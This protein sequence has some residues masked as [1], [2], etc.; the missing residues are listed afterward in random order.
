MPNGTPSNNSPPDSVVQYC[1]AREALRSVQAQVHNERTENADAR[2]TLAGMLRDSM[3]RHN[4][5]CV[6]L[7]GDVFVRM[8]NPQP[9][10]NPVRSED[11]VR[12]VIHGV[13]EGMRG[14][15]GAER[16]RMVM[17]YVAERIKARARDVAPRA[18]PRVCITKRPVQGN[19]VPAGATSND[20]RQLSEQ[21][22]HACQQ[23]RAIRDTVKPLRDAQR[24]TEKVLIES[25][26]EPVGVRMQRNGTAVDM[27]VV[28]C[29]RKPRTARSIGIRALLAMCRDA[30]EDGVASDDS[31]FEQDFETRLLERVRAYHQTQAQSAKGSYVKV[32]RM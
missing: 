15:H 18:E 20:V 16:P 10:S 13:G 28:R 2:R 9:R 4:V 29:E 17:R 1:M 12:S 32:V 26:H 21:F 19:T 11:D 5:E 8:T 25:L 7:A 14:I 27:R 23:T 30:A 6:G 31:A 3:V 24:E 22:A